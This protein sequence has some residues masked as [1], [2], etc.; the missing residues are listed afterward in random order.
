M[1]ASVIFVPCWQVVKSRRLRRE[2]LE[3]LAEWETKRNHSTSTRSHS[4]ETACDSSK[5]KIAPSVRTGGSRRGEIYTMNA[6]EKALQTNPTPLLLFAALK[7]FSG[8]NISFLNHVRDWKADWTPPTER[9][10]VL[11]KPHGKRRDDDG[12]RRR[13]FTAAAQIYAS[14]VSVKYSDFPINLSFAHRKELGALFDGATASIGPQV[15][16]N[17][18]TPFDD[19]ERAVVNDNVFVASTY[20]NESTEQILPHSG[21]KSSISCKSIGLAYL[22][23]RLRDDVTIPAHFGPKVFDDAEES[24]KYMVLTN[25]WPKFVTAGYA[26]NVE[27]RTLLER[28]RDI[29]A[30]WTRSYQ[31]RSR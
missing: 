4:T 19:P 20:L 26:S 11:K 18:V 23:G 28:F 27:Q 21:G 9:V 1:E 3:I 29:V 12:L 8:E 17:P 22:D 14:F 16:N 10:R 7:D 15:H 25:T 2:T 30:A 31:P 24:I 6:L 13:Q 5:Q